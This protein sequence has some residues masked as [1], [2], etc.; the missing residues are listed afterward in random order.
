MTFHDI[1]NI[2]WRTNPTGKQRP[3]DDRP[4]ASELK[5]APSRLAPLDDRPPLQRVG[6]LVEIPRV[7]HEMNVDPE[8]LL[9]SLGSHRAALSDM[10]GWLP[11]PVISDLVLKCIAATGGED[12]S[13]VVGASARVGHWGIMGKLVSAAPNLRSALVEFVANHPR[14]A[15]G[16]GAYLVDGREDGLLVGYRIHYPGLR[17]VRGLQPRRGGVRSQRLVRT[18]RRRTDA[19]PSISTAA[20]GLRALQTRLRPS[21]PCL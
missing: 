13:L 21:E 12:F 19:R 2:R 7:L 18:L 15:R 14:Y 6:V 17:G 10:D 11:F 1:V 8:P 9:A 4:N 16:A 20:Q 3:M 5:G